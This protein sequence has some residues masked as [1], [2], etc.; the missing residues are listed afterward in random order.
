MKKNVVLFVFMM[1]LVISSCKK[2]RVCE[3]I[4]TPG[5]TTSKQT[6]KNVTNR[7]AK[8]NCFDYE[9]DVMSTKVVVDCTIK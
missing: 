2:D 3:C 9:Y 8:A 7:Q 4:T 1:S 6:L 5:N